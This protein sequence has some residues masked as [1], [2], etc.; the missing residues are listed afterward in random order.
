MFRL[1]AE[2]PLLE[3]WA[4]AEDVAGDAAEANDEQRHEDGERGVEHEI[5]TIVI[6]E[7]ANGGHIRH[8]EEVEQVDVERASSDVLQADADNRR[9]KYCW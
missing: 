2:E 8:E 3:E 1:A 5:V 7:V 4:D 6:E 9:V